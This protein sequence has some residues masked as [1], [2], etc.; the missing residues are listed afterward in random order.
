VA[1]EEAA[2]TMGDQ[3]PRVMHHYLQLLRL[4]DF[5]TDPPFFCHSQ[6]KSI[7][8]TSTLPL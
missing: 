2:V 3:E 6:T 5:Q 8:D 1:A 7:H 4:M